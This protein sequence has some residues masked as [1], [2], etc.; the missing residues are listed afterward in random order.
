MY[1]Q[2]LA[3]RLYSSPKFLDMVRLHAKVVL[4]FLLLRVFYGA[5][6]FFLDHC[7][8]RFPLPVIADDFEGQCGFRVLPSHHHV[9]CRQQFLGFPHVVR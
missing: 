3:F 1:A 5:G 4:I 7:F 2:N 8:D 9:R 6:T